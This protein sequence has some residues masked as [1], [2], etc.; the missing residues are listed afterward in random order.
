M[1]VA[2]LVG[3]YA[4]ADA[5]DLVPGPLTTK[6]ELAAPLPYPT[7]A[8]AMAEAPSPS[9]EATGAPPASADVTE[10]INALAADPRNTGNTAV[11]V[12]DALTGEVIGE[13]EADRAALPASNMKIVTAAVALEELGAETTL[14]TVASLSGS[15]L[16][17]VGGGDVLLAENAGDPTATVGRAGLGDLAAAAAAE[18]RDR[19]VASV[20]VA[21]DS[22]LFTGSQYHTDIEGANRGYVMELRPIAI[23]RGRVQGVGYLPNPDVVAAEAF[24]ERLRE[25]GI[26]VTGV[27]RSAAAP[28]AAEIARVESAPIREIV[29]HTLLVSDNSVA[30]VLGHLAGISAGFGGTFE[31][32]S[33]AAMQILAK[34]GVRTDGLILADASGL[35]DTNRLTANALYDILTHT[36][37]CEAC[38][39]A[40]IPA[41]LPVGGLDGTL[42]DRFHDTDIKGQVR[43]KTGTLVEA[44]S[45]SGYVLT[46]SGYPLT[47]VILMDGLDEGTAPA[48]RV[49][50]DE[51]L[52]RLAAL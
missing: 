35:S 17:L 11:V 14:P 12:A 27:E 33:Q 52:A 32:A 39:L 38:P 6:P 19:G 10:A 42:D 26:D 43:A 4:F 28:D 30:E 7:I 22:T 40:P 44:I 47:F 25:N 24:A 36:W 29:D 1:L 51:F 15:T 18:L 13:R 8:S 37:D 41:G 34:A 21:V 45:L 48:S 50:Q 46:D 5:W 16:Y 49:L 31:G 20:N 23:D 2:V 9:A 3:G